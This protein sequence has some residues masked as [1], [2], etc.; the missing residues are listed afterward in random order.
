MRRLRL[1]NSPGRLVKNRA[2]RATA[3]SAV[4]KCQR[5][6]RLHGSQSRGTRSFQQSASRRANRSGAAVAIVLI[7][8]GVFGV[9]CQTLTMLVAIQHR[10]VLQQAEQAQAHRL[11]EAGLLRAS[12]TLQRDSQWKGETWKPTLP[13]GGSTAVQLSV[14]KDAATVRVRAEAIFT[15]AA[16]RIHKSNQTLDVLATSVREVSQGHTP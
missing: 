4:C 16:G 15:T 6:P 5:F 3:V 12:A 13:P 14:T 9:L 8:I 1:E 11:A 10:Q 2:Q 7:L